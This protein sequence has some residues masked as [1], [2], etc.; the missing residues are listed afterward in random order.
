MRKGMGKDGSMTAGYPDLT[1]NG[2]TDNQGQ[3][4]GS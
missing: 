2:S 4:M 1:M 3:L